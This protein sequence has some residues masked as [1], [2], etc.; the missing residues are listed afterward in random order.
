MD[1]RYTQKELQELFSY[2]DNDGGGSIG[3]L[4]FTKLLDEKR[5]G[6]DPYSS[7]RNDDEM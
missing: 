4:E 2:L 1:L 7:S 3:Y 5:L 6:I